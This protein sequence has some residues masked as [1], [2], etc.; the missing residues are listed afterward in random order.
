MQRPGSVSNQSSWPSFGLVNGWC[1]AFQR[2]ASSSYSNI[3]KSTT[4]S[5]SQSPWARPCARP[6]SLCPIF[7]RKAPM[8]SFT[9]FALSAPK[10]KISPLAAPL[11]SR[12]AAM[13]RSCRFFTMG[14]C[15]P[16]RPKLTSLTLIHAKPLAP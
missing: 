9:T 16:S 2:C 6:N 5:G 3:G 14:L 12:M 10:N 1:T 15:K 8:A 7:T 13:A 11:R 4:Q